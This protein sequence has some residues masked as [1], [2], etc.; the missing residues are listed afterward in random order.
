MYLYFSELF[1]SRRYHTSPL[2]ASSHMSFL[3]TLMTTCFYPKR[4]TYHIDVASHNLASEVLNTTSG[5]ENPGHVVISQ[6]A[7][8]WNRIVIAKLESLTSQET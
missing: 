5:P 3:C 7:E 8:A 4:I 2:N 6:S 1:G